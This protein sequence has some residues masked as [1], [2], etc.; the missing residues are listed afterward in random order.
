LFALPN[1]KLLAKNDHLQSQAVAQNQKRSRISEHRKRQRHHQS[2]LT[3]RPIRLLAA[4]RNCLILLFY[5]I[6]MTHH[7]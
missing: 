3:E 5:Q 4:P 2:D 1:R 7:R 6:L